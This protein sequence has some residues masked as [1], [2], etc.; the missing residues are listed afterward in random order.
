MC[1]K[2]NC[3]FWSKMFKNN[4]LSNNFQLVKSKMSRSFKDVPGKFAVYFPSA[5]TVFE[6]PKTKLMNKFFL[7][8]ILLPTTYLS[9][10]MRIHFNLQDLWKGALWCFF[11]TFKDW[12]VRLS[13]TENSVLSIGNYS[14]KAKRFFEN[15]GFHERY[16]KSKTFLNFN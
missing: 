10:N 4:T 11:F 2:Y 7:E 5:D 16:R 8:W 3:G 6:D 1:K 14:G 12:N 13:T 9:E 15:V